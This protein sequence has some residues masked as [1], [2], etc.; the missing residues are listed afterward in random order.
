MKK[1]KKKKIRME[2]CISYK[3]SM[4]FTIELFFNYILTI[5]IYNYKGLVQL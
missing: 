2:P 5:N 1:K 4:Y 3:L